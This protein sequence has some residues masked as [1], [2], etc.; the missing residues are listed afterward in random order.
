MCLV[1]TTVILVTARAIIGFWPANAE[2]DD[3]VVWADETRK[4]ERARFFTLRQH[5]LSKLGNVIT[6]GL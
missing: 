3:I 1:V 2:G 5:C 6:G 4:I